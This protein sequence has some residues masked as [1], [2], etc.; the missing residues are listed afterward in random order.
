MLEINTTATLHFRRSVRHASGPRQ[1]L[2]SRVRSIA[3]GDLLVSSA[4]ERRL[5]N[6]SIQQWQLSS[7]SFDAGARGLSGPAQIW[8]PSP[9]ISSSF[10]PTRDE[11][12]ERPTRRVLSCS[13]APNSRGRRTLGNVHRQGVR[14]NGA[15]APVTHLPTLCYHSFNFQRFRLRS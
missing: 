9:T 11:K 4:R 13:D 14:A 10:I 5:K 1:H 15:R 8:V 6:T 2:L 7:K 3:V 12:E